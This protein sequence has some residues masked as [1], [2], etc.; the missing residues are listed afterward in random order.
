[1]EAEREREQT[2]EEEEAEIEQHES[3]Q[4]EVSLSADMSFD[5][6]DKD[7]GPKQINLSEYPQ[8]QFGLQMRA[9]LV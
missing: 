7:T 1:M 4:A 2:I 6:G 9:F 3:Q 5:L 8:D